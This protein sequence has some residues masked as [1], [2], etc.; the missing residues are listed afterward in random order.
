MAYSL[1]YD[2]FRRYLVAWQ[3]KG[4][5]STLTAREEGIQATAEY[6]FRRFVRCA[7]APPAGR[8]LLPRPRTCDPAQ[9]R[10]PSHWDAVFKSIVRKKSSVTGRFDELGDSDGTIGGNCPAE[11][12]VEAA[13]IA[14]HLLDA[15][16]NRF[17]TSVTYGPEIQ[18]A[19][20][21]AVHDILAGAP[22]SFEHEVKA[23]LR[24]LLPHDM[25]DDARGRQR[26]SRAVG[27]VRNLL[28]WV[29]QQRGADEG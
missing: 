16:L 6:F 8:S 2:D 17:D 1:S 19:M 29:A 21:L 26:L 9:F 20:R 22:L 13:E 10:D 15:I 18:E 11:Q 25:G 14:D 12:E 28:Q 23:N 5:T 24:E 27:R 7:G 3:P 4:A